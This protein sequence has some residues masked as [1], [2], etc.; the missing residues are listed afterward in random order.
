MQQASPG[1]ENADRVR[2]RV[3]VTVRVTVTVR[4]RVRVRIRIRI[5]VIIRV[6]VRSGQVRI[7]VR[8]R[9]RAMWRPLVT[10][11][12]K[13]AHGLSL[14]HAAFILI[15]YSDGPSLRLGIRLELGLT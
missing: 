8:V 15:Q 5:R 14:N 4:V 9:V 1:F 13:P 7:R 6:R 10:F 3:R 2:V 11:V 12:A